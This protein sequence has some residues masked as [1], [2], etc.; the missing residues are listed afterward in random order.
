M[1]NSS[2]TIRIRTRDALNKGLYK[3]IIYYLIFLWFIEISE[4]NFIVKIKVFR[5]KPAI[6]LPKIMPL[7][8]W[9]QGIWQRQRNQTNNYL[10]ILF[11]NPVALYSCYSITF[12]CNL[13][14]IPL[15][16]LRAICMLHNYENN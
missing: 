5:I 13:F 15:F 6:F 7:S 3:F 1:K 11:N 16:I 9:L 2:D 14:V 10:H 8:V 12:F 4:K